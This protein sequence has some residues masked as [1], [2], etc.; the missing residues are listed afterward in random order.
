MQDRENDSL[1]IGKKIH[2]QIFVC[3]PKYHLLNLRELL[4]LS[5]VC[6]A[7]CEVYLIC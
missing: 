1:L 4:L 5:F 3:G 7:L 2:I 6:K